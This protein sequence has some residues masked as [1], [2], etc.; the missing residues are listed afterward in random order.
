M[1]SDFATYMTEINNYDAPSPRYS[2]K[3]Y[4]S[5]QGCYSFI[6]DENLD[7]EGKP[8]T[9]LEFSFNNQFIIELITQR[10]WFPSNVHNFVSNIGL[11]YQNNPRH[12]NFARMNFIQNAVIIEW[13]KL[14]TTHHKKGQRFKTTIKNISKSGIE[15]PNDEYLLDI[16]DLVRQKIAD[17]KIHNKF[18]KE[19]NIKLKENIIKTLN[20]ETT[21]KDK[22]NNDIKQL[23][24]LLKSKKEKLKACESEIDKA[25]D[26]KAILI[27][28]GVCKDIYSV[29][30]ENKSKPEL[31]F[32]NPNDI[33]IRVVEYLKELSN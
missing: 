10:N 1:T 7:I 18:V 27:F 15:L 13:C 33:T 26:M 16:H 23:E 6:K 28:P 32:H 2:L 4:N 9:S 5:K 22:L 8:M 25:N 14:W 21:K 11:L 12:Y 19:N 3:R 29:F 20:T 17:K 31:I 30:S 24:E